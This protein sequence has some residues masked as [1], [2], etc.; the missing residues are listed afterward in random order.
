MFK[1]GVGNRSLRLR[2]TFPK[3]FSKAGAVFLLVALLAAG[4]PVRP[5]YAAAITST[6]AGGY[7][8]DSSTWVDG[9]VPVAGDDVVID[10]PVTT[11]STVAVV[12]LT[13]NASKTLTLGTGNLTVSGIAT[14]NGTIT[15][16]TR[17]VLA[18]GSTLD[19]TGSITTTDLV[20]TVGGVVVI[21]S[22]ASLTVNSQMV[23]RSGVTVTNNGAITVAN[24][25]GNNSATS[26]WVNAANSTLNISGP[27]LATG[28]LTATANPNTVN[29]NG[30]AQTV[31][32]TTYHHLTL[33]GSG[34][35][36]VSGV[37]TANGN[38]TA[39]NNV[40]FSTANSVNVGGNWS[41]DG[42]FSQTAGTT[43]FTGGGIHT[44]SG[45]GSSQ[46]NNLI[47]SSQ[48]INAGASDIRISA[49]WTHGTAGLFNEQT[50]TVTFNGS[51]N[52]TQPTIT[53]V[54]QL[55]NMTVNKTG[56]TMSTRVWTV[57]NDFLLANGTFGVSSN[58]SFN[59]FTISGGTFTAPT[60]NINVSGN[61]MNSGVFTS[62]AG[63]VIF[64]GGAVQ[65]IGGSSATA[66]NNLGINN[67]GGVSLNG[68]NATVNGTLTFINGRIITGANTLIVGGAVSGAG[69]DGYVY[70][71]LQKPVT[72]GSPVVAFE[73]GGV[74]NYAPISVMFTGLSGD[75][76]LTG[77][78]TDNLSAHPGYASIGFTT[79]Y[80]NRYWTLM[81]GGLAF[82]SYDAT[83]NFVAGDYV[84]S[85]TP[86]S[87]VVQKY[88]GSWSQAASNTATATSATG[89]GFTS[90][91]DFAVGNKGSVTPVTLSY[92]AAQRVGSEVEI[93]WSTA[94]EIGNL[95]FNLYALEGDQLRQLNAN[96]IPSQNSDSLEQQD[97][98]FRAETGGT[99]F[100]LE[101]V[102][103]Q[104]DADRHG[105]YALAET[106]GARGDENRIDWTA[107]RDEHEL[108]QE[109]RQSTLQSDL[110]AGPIKSASFTLKVRQTGLYRVT[111]EMLKN[112]GL[113]LAGVPLWKVAL[114]NR[115]QNV[116]IY[117]KGARRFGPGAYIE[118]YGQALDTSYTDTNVY[119]LQVGQIPTG[120]ILANDVI[121][122]RTARPAASYGETLVVNNQKVYAVFAPGQDAWYDTGMLV[123]AESKT[124][125]FPF[126]VDSLDLSA[127]AALEVVVWGMTDWP[128]GDDHHL[129]VSLND[130]PLS[131]QFFDG[132]AEQTL[133]LDLPAG[134]LVEGTNTLQLTLPG[135]TGVQAEQVTLDKFSVNYQRAFRAKD[136][137]LTFT[138]MGRVFQVTNLPGRN[139]VV[140]RLEKNRL[141]KLGQVQVRKSGDTFV[142]VFAGTNKPATYF[143]STVESLYSPTFEAAKQAVDLNR[144]AQYLVIAHP[145][146][147][148]GLQP[149][150]QAR[151]AQGLAVSVVD[152]TDLYAQYSYGIFDPTAIQKYIAYA[153][154]NLG[155]EYILLVGGDTYDYRN[156]LGINSLSFIPSLYVRIG[157]MAGLIPADPLFA[158]VDQ[159]NVPDVAI[160]RFPVRT[161]AELD[162]LV[163]K[164]LAYASKDYGRTFVFASDR[165]DRRA[166]F[167]AISVGFALSLPDHWVVEN[168]H[169]ADVSVTAART[170]LLDAMNR[171]TALVTFTGHSSPRKWSSSNLFDFQDAASLTNAGKPF[172]VVQWG[173]FNSYHVNPM[174]NNLTQ[175]FLLSGD[176][177]AAAMLGATT[178][179]SSTSEELLGDLLTPRLTQPG[180]TLGQAVQ[181]SKREL[182]QTHPDLLDVLLGWSLM[183]DPALVIE[184]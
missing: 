77:S 38:L 69:A 3:I 139:V 57:T 14:V 110:S 118:F 113:D 158:D 32:A 36:T 29:Y 88:N 23:V 117:V 92:F 84:G 25:T 24:I 130:V 175:G 4:L 106:Y 71:N 58:S 74:S 108:A 122:Y 180:M 134:L 83:F 96:L 85:P 63:T 114:T 119:T 72:T 11:A 90:F 150:V 152:V 115:G 62:S 124:W 169:L 19:G 81:P 45:I 140:Y 120:R 103:L 107:I 6:V 91:S 48:T 55:Y 21:A 176:R 44:L 163:N 102:D 182:A 89:V 105:P 162:M 15:G 56:G 153:A 8:E 99:I 126:Q 101:E 131:D 75:G 93:E 116:P 173:C 177:G 13:V 155:T 166:S 184:P 49:A 95:G 31:K 7:W 121:P 41:V 147:I 80:I 59:N 136:G 54:P 143:V 51:G 144:P 35:K 78:T 142:A 112:A 73:V 146:F 129:R 46:F 67:A 171:G 68:V 170:Q 26:I 154:Q 181:M 168:I 28:T 53:Y 151:Q 16:S 97:Y 167:K 66:F 61:W 65:T 10:G 39:N 141:V 76:T 183:G 20:D 34:G 86:G 133:K 160:G 174:Y 17:L 100:Y 104:G 161:T 52:Q 2:V 60:G 42:T 47:T 111:Y 82:T 94:T 5:V 138:A 145:N 156:Y 157:P 127:P 178:L 37:V 179:A 125:S 148:A 98:S 18:A 159:D 9:I 33:S 87:M 12:N 137:R 40:A 123:R 64:N 165:N 1:S 30:A 79:D 22:T 135:D 149:L 172:V 128:K 70:G 27:L 164:T 109:S 43:T 50:S 132:R